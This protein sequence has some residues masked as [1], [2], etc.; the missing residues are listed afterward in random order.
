MTCVNDSGMLEIKQGGTPQSP[1]IYSG[2]GQTPVGGIRVE[3]DYVVVQG[4]KLDNPPAPGIV[5]LGNNI[6]LQDNTINHPVGD[7]FD[8]IRFFGNGIKILHNTI[9]NTTNTDGHHAD[10][11]QTFTNGKPSTSN[12]LIASNKCLDIANQCLMAEGPG[13]P[14]G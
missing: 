5:A 4:F 10:C 3:A 7:D 8:G 14:E 13:D 2:N 6:T 12:L 11:M 1:V 9:S